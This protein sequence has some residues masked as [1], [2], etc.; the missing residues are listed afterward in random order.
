MKPVTTC[1]GQM[2][3]A[4][5]ALRAL[6]AADVPSPALTA[7]E[8]GYGSAGNTLTGDATL[9]WDTIKP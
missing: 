6:V 5:E 2:P 9:T 3:T 7:T 4:L 1:Y 8:I